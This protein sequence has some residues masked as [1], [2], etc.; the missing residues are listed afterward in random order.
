MSSTD[1]GLPSNVPAAP[2]EVAAPTE[3]PGYSSVRTFLLYTLSIP[4]RTLRSGAGLVGGAVRESAA[5]L[6]PQAFQDSTTYRVMV[7]QMLDFMC[8]DVAGVKCQEAAGATAPPQVE[9]FVA[10]KAV[11]NFVEMAGLATLHVSPLTLLAIVSDVAYGS[12]AYLKELAEELKK[13][14]VIDEHSTIHHV[15]D[16][17]AAV[18]MASKTTAAAFDTPPISVEGL[19]Q[20]IDETRAAIGAIDPT[21]VVPQAEMQKLWAEMHDLA[22]KE[23]VG[24]LE[25][26]G[27]ATLRMLDKAGTLGRGALSGVQ[28]AGKLLDRHVLNHYWTAVGEIREKGFYATLAETSGPYIEAVWHNF[29]S[30][31]ATLTEDLLSGK[32]LGQAWGVVSRWLG[33][34]SCETTG[35]V[36]AGSTNPP[37]P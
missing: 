30:G 35:G 1:S 34:G 37:A 23:G 20:T 2:A 31:R 15:D 8:R 4:E 29:S 11:G 6:V 10:R 28:V 22:T 24:I 12:Q 27:A 16:L 18:A 32:T 14:G 7:Q 36:P 19:K 26:S 17:L 25:I 5:L 33:I 13:E 21:R 3:D 9:N